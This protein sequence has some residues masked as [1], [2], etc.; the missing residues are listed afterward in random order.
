MTGVKKSW[1][2][3]LLS[4]ERDG[5][6]FTVPEPMGGRGE[7]LFGGMI[8]AQ[9]LGAAGATV[10]ADK[11]PQSL[12]AYFIRG[13]K[14]G[15]ELQFQVER[16]RDGRAFD[17]RRVTALQEGKAILEMIASFHTPEV[18]ADWHPEPPPALALQD[19]LPKDPGLSITDHLEIRTA[20][21]DSTPFAVPPYWVRFRDAVA[22]PGADT[23][24]TRACALTFVTDLGPVPAARPAGTPLRP[25]VGF[26]ASLDH[27]VWFHR[28]YEPTAWHRYE[29]RSVNNSDNRGLVVGSMYDEAGSLVASMTQEALWRL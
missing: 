25:D 27:A 10:E 6:T 3:G 12:H 21:T 8:A 20:V 11:L 5:D 2:A 22:E 1:I 13:G 17:T 4:F 7:R 9:A 15:V 14:F 24:L 29:V 18:G 16:T 26:A 19:A 28:P 23:A